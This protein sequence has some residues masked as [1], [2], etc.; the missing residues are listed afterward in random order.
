MFRPVLFSATAALIAVGVSVPVPV[1]PA[2]ARAPAPYWKSQASQRKLE[3]LAVAIHDYLSTHDDQLPRNITDKDGRPLLSWRVALLPHLDLDF[4]Y[5]QFKL[6]ESWDGPNNKKLAAFMPD[7]FRDPT[8]DRGTAD[9]YYQAVI[10]SGALFDPNAKVDFAN[11]DD[12]L[13]QTLLLVEAGPPVAWSKPTDIPFDPDGKPP[14]LKGPYT[15]A[16]HVAVA[17]GLTFRMKVK[18]APDDLRAF[19]TRAGGE[20]LDLKNLRADPAKP[21]TDEDKKALASKRDW[22]KDVLREAAGNAADRF[23]VEEALRKFGALPQP[24][25]AAIKTCEELDEAMKDIQK[26][27]W[28]DSSEYYRL[29]EV[30]EKKDPKAAE[31]IRKARLERAE[32]GEADRK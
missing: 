20:V 26:R 11:I 1:A 14:A 7:V 22:A 18:P 27:R 25:P 29:I 3:R 32:K 6:D 28:A 23:K 24:N 9:T 4:L 31:Q 13:S 17:D 15:D 19:I 5:A 16:V 21:I 10:G 30:L 8:Q 2:P 12:G